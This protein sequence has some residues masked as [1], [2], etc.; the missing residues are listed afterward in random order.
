MIYK[1]S[2]DT[3]TYCNR[4]HSFIG[5]AEDVSYPLVV[6]WL[7]TDYCNFKCKYCFATDIENIDLPD[8]KVINWVNSSSFLKVVI[9]G[10]E[11]F[12]NKYIWEILSSVSSNTKSLVVDTNGSY[13]FSKSE[14]SFLKERNITLRISLDS[15]NPKDND[16][17]RIPPIS[18]GY[19]MILKNIE[20]LKREGGVDVEIQTVVTKMNIKSLEKLSE[21]ISF[22]DIT[23]WYIQPIIPSGRAENMQHLIPTVKSILKESRKFPISNNRYIIKEDQSNNAVILLT[24]KGDIITENS[25]GENIMIGNVVSVDPLGLFKHI[26]KESHLNRYKLTKSCSCAKQLNLF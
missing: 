12:T 14:M 8:Q 9:S 13:K 17:I 1:R 7:I 23:K 26:E 11:S 19:S 22:L 3:T 18:S 24:N 4:C 10:G 5:S 2:A 16:S 21:V 6:N 25:S 15:A 20:C